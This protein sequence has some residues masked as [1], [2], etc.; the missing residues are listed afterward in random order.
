M[1]TIDDIKQELERDIKCYHEGVAEIG[2]S[3]EHSFGRQYQS[4]R[5][6]LTAIKGL[7]AIQNDTCIHYLKAYAGWTLNEIVTNWNK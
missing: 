6:L 5:A 1:T 4:D 2:M 7:E 3:F